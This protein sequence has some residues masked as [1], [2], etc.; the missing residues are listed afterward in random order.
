MGPVPLVRV[1]WSPQTIHSISTPQEPRTPSRSRLTP[2]PLHPGGGKN[3]SGRSPGERGRRCRVHGDPPTAP[4]GAGPSRA[5]PGAQ[6]PPLFPARP[7]PVCASHKRVVYGAGA[8]RSPAK[9][10]PS[11]PRGPGLRRGFL[12]GF[13]PPFWGFF[14]PPA[15]PRLVGGGMVLSAPEVWAVRRPGLVSPLLPRRDK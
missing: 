6:W 7:R 13:H 9:K 5:D 8:Q 1:L 15:A 2:I 4:S 3:P 12:G 10:E 14:T 11:V